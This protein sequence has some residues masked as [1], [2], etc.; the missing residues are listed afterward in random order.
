MVVIG[1]ITVGGAGKTPLVIAFSELLME[2]GC[3]VGIVTIGYGG[4][5]NDATAVAT[6]DSDPSVVGDE[7]V[8]SLIHI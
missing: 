3:R 5:T 2:R 8:L 1:N 4:T 7:P 6:Q